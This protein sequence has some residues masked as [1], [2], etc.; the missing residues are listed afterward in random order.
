[1]RL[2]HYLIATGLGTGYSP[3][4]PGTMGSLLAVL[5][6]L[7]LLPPRSFA[8]LL[9][10]LFGFAHGVWSS[11]R[12]EADMNSNDP[13]IVVIDEI[14][15]M[16]VGLLFLPRNLWLFLLAFILF[17]YLDIKKP[18]GLNRLQSLPNGWGIMLDDVGAGFYTLIAM[19]LLFWL[20]HSVGYML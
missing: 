6:A 20:L 5:I 19:Q 14:V 15:G 12:V 2:W 10:L 8:F 11:T 17:R 3:F 16:W 13:S 7:F 9:V 4:A 18:L 1:M